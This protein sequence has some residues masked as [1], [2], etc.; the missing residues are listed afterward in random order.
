M[1]SPREVGP[2]PAGGSGK[3][4]ARGGE[5][6]DLGRS[7]VSARRAW[8]QC[9]IVLGRFHCLFVYTAHH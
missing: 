9:E 1:Q 2:S 7:Q 3:R 5:P 4:N 8:V 6:L